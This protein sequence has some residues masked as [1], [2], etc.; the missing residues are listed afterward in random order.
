MEF[1]AT[2]GIG[3]NAPDRMPKADF[4]VLVDGKVRF[5]K[6][7]VDK[8]QT[9]FILVPISEQDEF[10]TLIVSDGGP[11]IDPGT[12]EEIRPVDCDWGVFLNPR[13]KLQ[14]D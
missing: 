3:E 5:C 6:T 12:N 8:S 10:L 7:A 11:Q 13:L 2:C 9:H 4:W 1:S 14:A